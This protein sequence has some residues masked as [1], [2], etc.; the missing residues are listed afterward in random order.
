MASR[1]ITR[2]PGGN[3]GSRTASSTSRACERH[4]QRSIGGGG[5][6]RDGTAHVPKAPRG[7][8]S[9]SGSLVSSL[10]APWL[11]L[12]VGPRAIR[13]RPPDLSTGRRRR[14]L[15]RRS[16]TEAARQRVGGR[17]AA[18]AGGARLRGSPWSFAIPS[19][20]DQSTA[21]P[22]RTGIGGNGTATTCRG[23]V[24]SCGGRRSVYGFSVL[25]WCVSGRGRCSRE[26]L[27]VRGAWESSKE[28]RNEAMF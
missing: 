23:V 12:R 17:E 16:R 25:W 27:E 10:P 18:P 24:G 15:A 26:E 8:R 5:R 4:V 1:E 20:H 21:L 19:W 28:D 6:G 11:P 2:A 9:C 14:S 3:G 13:R 7:A 22:P